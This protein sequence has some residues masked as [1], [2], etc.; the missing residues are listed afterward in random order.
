[1]EEEIRKQ[2]GSVELQYN[3][4]TKV[5]E[6]SF[7]GL[8]KLKSLD[9]SHNQ[10]RSINSTTFR[11]LR[12]LEELKIKHNHLGDIPDLGVQKSLKVLNLDH[13]E[14]YTVTSTVLEK[15]ENLEIL[16][17]DNN[18]I[19]DIPIDTF[20]NGSKLL[21]LNLN[22][23]RIVSIEEGALDNLT[24]L[25]T[26]KL[27]KNRLSAIPKNL[28]KKLLTLKHLELNKNHIQK[29]EGLSFHG[30]ESL[31]VL[32]LKRNRIE[33]LLD[34]A[35]WGLSK[36][37]HLHLDYNNITQVKKAWL[38]KLSSLKTLSLTYNSISEVEDEG[39]IFCDH[40][41]E[42]DLRHNQLHTVSK[43]MF[44]KLSKLHTLDLEYN[45]ISYI[46]EGAFGHLTSL[47]TLKLDHNEISWTIEDTDGAFSNLTHLLDLGLAHNKIKSIAK[48]AFVGL[49]S[50]QLLDLTGNPLTAI[51]ENAFQNLHTLQELKFNTSSLLCDCSLKWLPNWLIISGFS[52]SVTAHCG[53]P[54]SLKNRSIFEASPENFTCDDSPKPY[55][56][57]NP[58]TL[59]ALK[60]EN[61]TLVC[62][63]ASSRDT[64]TIF[65]WR[66][67]SKL[68]LG[69]E[70]ENFNKTRKDGVTEHAS[71]LHIRNIDDND[72]GKYQCV[73]SN[74]FGTAY[75][76]KAHV[77]VHVF[78]IFTKTPVDVVVKSG[79]TARLECAAMGLP[80]PE[81]AWQ[82]DGGDD[83]F[84]A[85]RER[86]MH[87]MPSDDV[88]FIVKV[89]AS[90]MGIYSC[91]AKNDAGMIM[92]NAT[93]TVLETPNFVKSMENKETR[94]GE[95][96]VLE[97][98]AAGSPKPKL[99]WMKDDA[100]LV[101]TERHFFT[102]DSQLLIIVQ[103]KSSDTGKYVCNMSNTMGSKSDSS[104]LT[105]LPSLATKVVMAGAEDDK[106]TTGIIIISVVCCVVGTSLVWVVIIYKTRKRGE[107]YAL[108]KTD[109][110]TLPGETPPYNPYPQGVGV[111][112]YK[113][114]VTHLFLDN[115]SEHSS[116][117]SGTDSAKQSSDQLLPPEENSG[118]VLLLPH[119]RT[120]LP[121]F[122]SSVGSMLGQQSNMSE[123]T[124]QSSPRTT[125]S[126]QR[127]PLLPTFHSHP[128]DKLWRGRPISA[129]NQ[130]ME[131]EYRSHRIPG[132]QP[133][134][135]GIKK[136][137]SL[138]VD[139]LEVNLRQG[140]IPTPSR[141]CSTISQ[142]CPESEHD[143][144]ERNLLCSDVPNSVDSWSTCSLKH[145]TASK[146]DQNNRGSFSLDNEHQCLSCQ[147]L[148]NSQ[149]ASHFTSSSCIEVQ[150]PVASQTVSPLS[151]ARVTR[152]PT[153]QVGV[154]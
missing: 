112:E 79:S 153:S 75:S 20:H 73:I 21:N 3:D 124:V 115:N 41:K 121:H 87:V 42:L 15:Y 126:Q 56:T 39:W 63:A 29:I 27:N 96:A 18:K 123:D 89:K 78:P 101:P 65:Q 139:H 28:F 85:A 9:L 68:L 44:A 127:R 105:V 91:T 60:G 11:H 47:L 80:S 23:N 76:D 30:L 34:G 22:S 97:C 143:V 16:N 106:T 102:A 38:Y 4:L 149:G 119:E 67:D 146:D 150:E 14:I 118:Q 50:L 145:G 37:H 59:T 108:T 48:R 120:T 95:T 35:F 81:I 90:D 74:R 131:D 26:L 99:A 135:P 140:A 152:S 114:S 71:L 94:V 57:E 154:A 110:T 137:R 116:R 107:D 64:P 133:Q 83:D 111:D 136:K 25:D 88:F 32:K 144:A 31:Q 84:P 132:G 53:H 104:Y 128:R 52:H 55:I 117:D 36:I 24:R 109:E 58:Q 72:E 77:T 62:K 147:P 46:E 130:A 122:R 33:Q 141:S 100:P 51:Q 12:F 7:D 61:T 129:T 40:L 86:R 103:T 98:M 5:E 113:N 6:N 69:G 134:W 49:H 17:L 93:L 13:N 92:A 82:K 125:S 142:E 70:M 19:V 45:K 138:S 43:D 10:I 54:E 66:K 2:Q 1:M 148:L 8:P 151:Q